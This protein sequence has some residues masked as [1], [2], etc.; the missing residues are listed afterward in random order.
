MNNDLSSIVPE[1]SHN[2]IERDC[3]ELLRFRGFRVIHTHGPLNRPRES[4]IPDLLCYPRS[5]TVPLWVEVKAGK[6]KLSEKQAEFFA[7]M[8]ER[9]VRCIVAR[10][11]K[12][13]E[14]L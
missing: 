14:N 11:V 6:D 1:Q 2:E 7:D 3:D 5:S 8:T 4:G 12:D 9:G 10:S 13:V